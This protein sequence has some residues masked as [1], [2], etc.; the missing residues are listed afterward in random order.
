[1]FL[2]GHS[3]HANRPHWEFASLSQ[4]LG[5]PSEI[6][7]EVLT[8]LEE[9]GL[10]VPMHGEPPAYLPAKDLET[11]T[12][13]EIVGAVRVA[14]DGTNISYRTPVLIPAV[15]GVMKHIEDAIYASLENRTLKDLILTGEDAAN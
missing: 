5:M 14:G 13:N 15:E 4:K 10:I 2:I 6:V 7:L 9:K 11:I 8:V 3:F 1:M 12:L